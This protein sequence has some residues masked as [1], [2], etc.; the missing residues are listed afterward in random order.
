MTQD[1]AWTTEKEIEF[2]SCI[3][4]YS[5]MT[6]RVDRDTMLENY[7]EGLGKRERFDKIDRSKVFHYAMMELI[8]E[9]RKK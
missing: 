7:I 6:D 1:N 2:I 8:M 3:G 4:T 5:D 9:R